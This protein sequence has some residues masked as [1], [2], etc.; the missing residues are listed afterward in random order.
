[1]AES[2][3]TVFPVTPERFA[4]LER[5]FGPR[6]ACGG[7]WCMV[8]RLDRR[9]FEAQKGAGNHRALQGLVA[10]GT[11]PGLLAYRDGVPVGW[12]ALAPREDYPRLVHSRIARPEPLPGTWA[13]SCFFVTPGIRGQGATLPLLRA[14]ARFAF[15]HG[16]RCLEGYPY[17]VGQNPPPVFA[18]MGLARSFLRTGFRRVA[19]YGKSRVLMRLDGDPSADAF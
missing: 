3:F 9:T 11:V 10:S 6:G 19:P 4:D 5:L 7:C 15:D 14:A 16:A 8:S 17:E 12:L 1:M 18:Y 13:V 2:P